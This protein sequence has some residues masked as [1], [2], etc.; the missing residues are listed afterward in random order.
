MV[1]P[2]T[3]QVSQEEKYVEKNYYMDR[4]GTKILKDLKAVV[5]NKSLEYLLD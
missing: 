1:Y 2:I 5:E 3:L 4:I